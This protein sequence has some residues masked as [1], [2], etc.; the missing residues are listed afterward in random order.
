[1][2]SA[3]G[4]DIRDDRKGTGALIL[5]HAAEKT[6]FLGN[7]ELARQLQGNQACGDFENLMGR[8]NQRM[9]GA[10]DPSK[11]QVLWLAGWIGSRAFRLSTRSDRPPTRVCTPR[12][13]STQP[14]RRRRA[15][16]SRRR[17]ALRTD[18]FPKTPREALRVC[19]DAAVG[20]AVAPRRAAPAVTIS[21]TEPFV[22]FVSLGRLRPSW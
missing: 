18:T 1:V 6:S 13:S 15:R 19:R 14:R 21:R 4:G 10:P 20:G 16:S 7:A 12:D 22:A 2:D 8:T 9:S 5:C 3:T 17:S 11:F